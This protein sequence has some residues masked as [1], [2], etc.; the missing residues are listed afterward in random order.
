MTRSRAPKRPPVRRS[1][2]VSR[3]QRPRFWHEPTNCGWG[4][5]P[6]LSLACVR[7][8]LHA[9]LVESGLVVRPSPLHYEL[10][11]GCN[12]GTD[13]RAAKRS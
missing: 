13:D 2:R 5:A 6:A 7:I 3:K 11:D 12:G 9:A 4:V 1:L 8:P 10:R